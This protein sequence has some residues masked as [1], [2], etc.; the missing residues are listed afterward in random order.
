MKFE[1]FSAT[2]L[3]AD[4]SYF[5]RKYRRQWNVLC[6]AHINW[7]KSVCVARKSLA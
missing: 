1:L 5:I 4:T 7:R 6:T 3:F 2:E